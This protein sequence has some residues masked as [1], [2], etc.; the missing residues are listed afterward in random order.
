MTPIDPVFA[1]TAQG[2]VG[3]VFGAAAWHKLA[4][5][6]EFSAVLRAYRLLPEGWEPVAGPALAAAELAVAVGLWVPQ[7][8]LHATLAGMVL[9]G[10]Y[11]AAIGL[12]LGRGRR[13]ID[14]GC[15]WGGAPQPLSGWLL[16]RNAI[17]LLPLG[18]VAAE[19]VARSVSWLDVVAA[20]AGMLALAFCYR[21]FETLVANLSAL[22]TLQA[23][24]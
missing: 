23:A 15:T 4:A 21:A 1:W 17:L 20:M 18:L 7:L 6:R 14:C 3:I 24:P 16:L 9:L 12:N 5:R 22:R 11:A 19:R 13:D 8:R 2:L 10:L